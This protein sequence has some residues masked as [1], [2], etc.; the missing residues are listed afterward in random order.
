[1]AHCFSP[2]QL[3]DIQYNVCCTAR[4]AGLQDKLPFK[5]A[6]QAI[7]HSTIGVGLIWKR[8]RLL[9]Q[10]RK[11]EGLLG[12]LWEFPGG[13]RERGETLPACVRREVK[14]EL[15][16]EVRVKEEFA[17]VRHAYSHFAITMH[18]YTCEYIRGRPRAK[19]ADAVR[20]VRPA[21]LKDYAFPA[22]NRK[23]IARL[24]E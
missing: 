11:A 17:V 16:I 22:A 13:K 20:W 10:R 8:G 24:A 18:A 14:E 9:I 4:R 6:R 23:I 1:M 2:V 3:A 15:G 5:R 12:G 19:S 7:P 21:A